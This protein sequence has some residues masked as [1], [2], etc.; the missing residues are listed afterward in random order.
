MEADLRARRRAPRRSAAAAA[1]AAA[2]VAALAPA[3]GAATAPSRYVGQVTDA[4]RTPV[5]RLGTSNG[6]AM[7]DLVFVDHVADHTAYRTCVSRRSPKLSTCFDAVAGAE[8]V[9]NVTPLRFS[10]G[11][12]RVAWKVGGAVVA[13]WSFTVVASSPSTS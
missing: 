10:P 11:S 1:L 13:R 3:A 9:A 12:Y 8:D 5:H 6:R 7:A 4:L 2:L